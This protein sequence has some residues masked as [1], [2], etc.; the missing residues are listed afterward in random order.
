MTQD[1]PVEDSSEITGYAEQR[2]TVQHRRRQI[3][4][5]LDM[6]ERILDQAVSGP[7]STARH[8]N[9]FVNMVFFASL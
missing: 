5:A 4:V 7:M 2:T 1:D 8:P 6:V 9:K 3:K